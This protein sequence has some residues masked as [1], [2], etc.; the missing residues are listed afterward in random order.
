MAGMAVRGAASL[1][2]AY[3]PAIHV[4]IGSILKNASAR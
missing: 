3:A 1:S 2:L 4:S